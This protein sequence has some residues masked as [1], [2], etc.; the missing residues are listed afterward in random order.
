MTSGSSE[1]SAT[2][3]LLGVITQKNTVIFVIHRSSK[4]IYIETL[5]LC[6]LIDI[7]L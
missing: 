6:I 7:S 1:T 4:Y 5:Y 3:R 2:T